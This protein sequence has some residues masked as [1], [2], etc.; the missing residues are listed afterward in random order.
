M[1]ETPARGGRGE[2]RAAA[3]VREGVSEGEKLASSG[4]H[5]LVQG[6]PRI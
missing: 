3:V 2:R 5:L 4:C 1:E 6:S